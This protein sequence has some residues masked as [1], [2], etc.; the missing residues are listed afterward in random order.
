MPSISADQ[1][2]SRLTE[3]PSTACSIVDKPAP[4][5]TDPDINKIVER[6]LCSNNFRVLRWS[7]DSLSETNGFLGA[8]YTLSVTVQTGVG[9]KSRELKFFA[10]TPPP[11]VSPQY[12]FLVRTNTFNK[13]MDV[14]DDLMQRMG[15]GIGPKWIPD[16]YLGKD[17]T[18]IVLEDGKE[19]G[20]I[21]PDKFLTFDEEQCI[22]MVRALSTFHSRSLI[23]DEKLRRG[24]GQTISDLYRH[25]LVEVAFDNEMPQSRKYLS[26]SAK[27][28]VAMVDLVQGLT[29]EERRKLKDRVAR[30]IV[31]MP[32]LVIPSS[33]HRNVICHGDIWAN[34]IMFRTDSSSGRVAGCYIIDYQFIRYNPPA[35][36]FLLCLYLNTDRACRSAHF[37]SFLDLYCDTMAAELAS[38]GLNMEEC[39]SRAEFVQSCKDYTGRS[40]V[41]CATNLQIML[42]TKD[43]V[44]K[45]FIDS[46]DELEHVLYGD[47]RPE[48]VLSQCRSVKAYQT[49]I[50]EIL[51][52]I[53]EVLPDYPTNC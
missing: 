49:R 48:L 38:E 27:G 20:Y 33:K 17:N 51:E 32:E 52:E 4:P 30:W 37:T 40:L 26:S 5:L 16:Y 2:C 39:L 36:D 46:I 14:Y 28:A 7:L 53:K 6:K 44:E 8:Y 43:A 35:F 21:M 47:R 3:P 45:Y 19:S 12:T 23:L 10:K 9:D 13:E 41:Y 34:N 24:T 31:K 18:I 1:A 42:L 25:L 11:S 15:K 29:D 50:V 22:W